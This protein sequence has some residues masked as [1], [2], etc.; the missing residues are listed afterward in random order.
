MDDLEKRKQQILDDIKQ[1]RASQSEAA[2]ETQALRD[3]LKQKADELGAFD[4]L[5][6]AVKN[7]PDAA[8]KLLPSGFKTVL[9]KYRG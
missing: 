2:L 5:K 7:M 4:G 3:Q 1:L 6:Q 8:Y 9:G